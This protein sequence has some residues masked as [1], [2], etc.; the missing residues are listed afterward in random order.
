MRCS[1][2]HARP[3]RVTETTTTTTTTATTTAEAATTAMKAVLAPA[4]A[5]GDSNVS[6]QQLAAAA[7]TTTKPPPPPHRWSPPAAAASDPEA[8]PE[9]T[10]PSYAR[11][12][13]HAWLVV[14]HCHVIKLHLFVLSDHSSAFCSVSQWRLQC[15]RGNLVSSC[16]RRNVDMQRAHLYAPGCSTAFALASRTRRMCEGAR[17]SSHHGEQ[18]ALLSRNVPV[19]VSNMAT[20][21]PKLILSVR[22]THLHVDLRNGPR[23]LRADVSCSFVCHAQDCVPIQ[24]KRRGISA[25][26]YMDR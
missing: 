17:S 19:C 6:W 26:A 5:P 8:E 4:A 9:A 21:G 22:A 18:H 23:R 24:A 1:C 13:V 16:N 15:G 2:A 12:V 7:A 14:L 3:S 25:A 10:S 11:R 20:R